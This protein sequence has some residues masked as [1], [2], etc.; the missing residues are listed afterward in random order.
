V[1]KLSPSAPI[2]IEHALQTNCLSMHQITTGRAAVLDKL[3][4]TLS[5]T[6][7]LTRTCFLSQV[8]DYMLLE[9]QQ[10]LQRLLAYY[11]QLGLKEGEYLLEVERQRLVIK[12]NL[13]ELTPL[14][15]QANTDKL[16]MDAFNWLQP[17]YLGLINS[18]ELRQFAQCYQQSKTQAIAQF[19]HF[20][21]PNNGL[22]CKLIYGANLLTL[23]WDS[24]QH[25]F[26]L[27]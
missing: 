14:N 18:L 23:C 13:G 16:N 1:Y 9:T 21:L 12:N 24:P 6:R 19:C 7:S 4:P 22:S 15:D 5:L 2:L 11:R 20:E 3:M 27:P 17:N 8:D 10:L 25:R 26:Y